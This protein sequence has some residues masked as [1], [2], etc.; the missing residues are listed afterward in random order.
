[1][2]SPLQWDSALFEVFLINA[3][4]ICLAN[5]NTENQ[6]RFSIYFFPPWNHFLQDTSPR[7][8]AC[9]MSLLVVFSPVVLPC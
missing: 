4:A 8:L 1:M 6:R 2:F 9:H 3:S 7:Q 5:K